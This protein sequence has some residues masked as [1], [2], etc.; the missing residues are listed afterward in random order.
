ML[1]RLAYLGPTMLERLAYL[2]PTILEGL[3][4]AIACKGCPN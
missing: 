2:G 4:T 1:E 3:V